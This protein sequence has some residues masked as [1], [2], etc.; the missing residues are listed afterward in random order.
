MTKHLKPVFWKNSYLRKWLNHDFMDSA[1]TDD[2]K[3][4]IPTV[5]VASHEYYPYNSTQDQV[6]LLSVTEAERH[7]SSDD[8]RRYPFTDYVV[9]NAGGDV[10]YCHSWLRAPGRDWRGDYIYTEAAVLTTNGNI[11]DSYYNVDREEA[12]RPAM[13]IDLN[14]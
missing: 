7:F 2:E 13:W 10:K 11:Y 4:L 6:F 14:N 3:M 5:T 1:F 9:A 8:A 12:V